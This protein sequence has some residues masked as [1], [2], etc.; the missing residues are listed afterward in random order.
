MD[1][2]KAGVKTIPE[3]V[4]RRLPVYY[5][6]LRNI[7]QDTSAEYI[8]CT[9]IAEDLQTLPIQVRKDLEIAGAEGKPKIGYRV[10][11]VIKVIETFLG[12]NNTADVFLVG[13]GHLG[14]AL[15]G[16]QGFKDYGLNIIAAF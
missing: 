1:M 9:R 12:W 7:H 6:Y 3:P 11:E 10:A 8:S 16:Y 13:A 2:Q 5:Q 15:M 14:A 4:L